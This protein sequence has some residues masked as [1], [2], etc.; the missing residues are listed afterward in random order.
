MIFSV[1]TYVSIA[2]AIACGVYEARR[3]R[4]KMAWLL[5]AWFLIVAALFIIQ[6]RIYG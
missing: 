4:K 6:H 2:F 1:V 3:N 5:L